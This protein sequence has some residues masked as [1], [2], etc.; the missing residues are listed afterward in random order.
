ML[1][2]VSRGSCFERSTR[3]ASVA[4]SENINPIEDT[5]APAASNWMLL[6]RVIIAP[7]DARRVTKKSTRRPGIRERTQSNERVEPDSSRH[8]TT[9]KIT[10]SERNAESSVI[11]EYHI[12]LHHDQP[13]SVSLSSIGQDSEQDGLTMAA[14]RRCCAT[15]HLTKRVTTSCYNKQRWHQIVV[16]P[17]HPHQQDAKKKKRQ[18]KIQQ[19]KRKKKKNGTTNKG[20]AGRRASVR[21]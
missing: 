10:G 3:M 4:T 18:K 11:M 1:P 12:P 17:Q 9:T 7:S 20:T 6:A 15:N 14:V 5:S 2:L 16:V 21:Y 8:V 13:L 19:K